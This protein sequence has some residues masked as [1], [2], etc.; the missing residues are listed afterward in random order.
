MLNIDLKELLLKIA[1][2]NDLAAFQKIYFLYYERLLKLACSFVKQTEVAEEIVDDVFVKI[3][4]NRTKLNEVNNLTVYLY[5]A[6]KN[7]AFNYNQV[8]RI[9]CVDIESVGF[10]L[11][12]ISNS[13]EDVL[14]TAELAK[15]I[16]DAVQ[17][18]PEQ[19]KMVF[20]LVKEDRLKYR[21][22]AEILNI[23]P[24]T[25]EYHMGNALKTIAAAISDLPGHHKRGFKKAS[26]N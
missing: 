7:Q 10:E 20:K 26:A 2:D 15:V 13:V 19:C 11:K 3:W 14:I 24:K 22:V 18:L 25:V 4:A 23:S 9:I 5:V 12:D 17:R 21:N 1:H 6:I 16:N 8:N